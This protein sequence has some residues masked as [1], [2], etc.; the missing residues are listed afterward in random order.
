MDG[1]AATE[2]TGAMLRRWA[3]PPVDD[4]HGKE[5]RGR[6]VVVGG[7]TEIPGAALLAATSALRAG[8]GKLV[9]ATADSAAATIACAVPEAR[10]IGLPVDEEGE[11]AAACA[12]RLPTAV[13]RSDAVVLGP[14]MTSGA[15]AA[16]VVRGAAERGSRTT[17][18]IDA[19]ALEA[20]STMSSRPA[21]RRPAILTPHAGEMA[22]LRGLDIEAV[23]ADPLTVARA[24]AHEL[25]AV[26][27]AKG[28]V[29]YVVAP[30]GEAFVNRAAGCPGLGTSGSGDVLAGVIAGLVA[31][32]ADA[33]QAACWGVFLHGAAG[34]ALARRIGSIG[35]L[36]RELPGE[37]P[38][39]LDA[40]R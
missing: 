36:A 3:L 33:A 40:W 17:F 11:L 18:V 5:E 6:V 27:V 15:A 26:V 21:L 9:I 13:D 35:F 38:A 34:D 19:A 7:S 14:G 25:G 10:V 2:I 28:C 8:A 22:K 12:T 39:L 24:A 29:T 32:G 37:I 23:R 16:E 30:D 31:R 4:E 1:N 20:F